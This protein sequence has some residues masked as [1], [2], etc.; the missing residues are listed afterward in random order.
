P[1]IT[2]S[3]INMVL[4]DL[5]CK[6]CKKSYA[7]L[8]TFLQHTVSCSQPASSVHVCSL[9]QMVTNKKT[10]IDK[11]CRQA[12]NGQGKMRCHISFPGKPSASGG[13]SASADATA[14]SAS[15]S[16]SRKRARPSL[17][18]AVVNS[19]NGEDEEEEEE[20]PEG[21]VGGSVATTANQKRRLVARRR[22]PKKAQQKKQKTLQRPSESRRGRADSSSGGS[23]SSAPVSVASAAVEGKAEPPPPP[24][25]PAPDDEADDEVSARDPFDAS[26]L[27]GFTPITGHL[28]VRAVRCGDRLFAGD[29]SGG[30]Q[31]KPTVRFY[32]EGLQVCQ[33]IAFL[34]HPDSIIQTPD[35]TQTPSCR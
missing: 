18:A 20:A 5:A 8:S 29:G 34:C 10:I 1:V 28:P 27:I 19:Q 9:C 23:D 24:A 33:Q 15:G 26:S 35:S 30:Q 3:R 16:N 14:A 7:D 2:I 17:R 13:T 31:A 4:V 12:H 25:P 22:Q 6:N 32:Q 11:H 21:A